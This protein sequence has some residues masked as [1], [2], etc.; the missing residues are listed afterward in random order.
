MLQLS[1]YIYRYIY[2]YI[3]SVFTVN[4]PNRKIMVHN[5]V[6]MQITMYGPHHGPSHLGPLTGL[7]V[8]WPTSSFGLLMGLGNRRPYFGKK[9]QWAFSRLKSRLGLKRAE[10]LT[11]RQQAEIDPGPWLCQSHHV[12]LTG[13]NCL[14]PCLAQSDY[15]LWAGRM[16]TGL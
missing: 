7:N 1:Y 6:V 9:I 14:G 8:N 5:W 15:R 16:Q 2:I 13:Q 10:Q 11:G 4:R 3:Y 12:L